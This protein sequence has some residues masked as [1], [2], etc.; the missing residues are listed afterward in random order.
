MENEDGTSTKV[1][2]QLAHPNEELTEEIPNTEI[3]VLDAN[4]SLFEQ[5][6]SGIEHEANIEEQKEISRMHTYV[7]Q[8]IEEGAQSELAN[9]LTGVQKPKTDFAKKAVIQPMKSEKVKVTMTKEEPIV[10]ENS[11]S[12]MPDLFTTYADNFR[13]KEEQD[14]TA[15]ITNKPEIQSQVVSTLVEEDKKESQKVLLLI[16][17]WKGNIMDLQL[18]SKHEVSQISSKYSRGGKTSRWITSRSSHNTLVSAI[19]RQV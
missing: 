1:S 16:A 10:F 17:C 7:K 9:K 13:D 2:L 11:K 8:T 19:I 12:V 3:E 4:E 15:R 18:A 14:N 6:E 5:I